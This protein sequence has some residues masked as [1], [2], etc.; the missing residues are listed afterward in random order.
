MCVYWWNTLK[1]ATALV[2]LGFILFTV[3]RALF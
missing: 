3:A 1:A 2:L